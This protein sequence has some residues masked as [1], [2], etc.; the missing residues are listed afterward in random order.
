M[1]AAEVLDL[2]RDLIR[3]DTT[4]TGDADTLTG[5]R[6]AAEYVAERLSDAGYAPEYVEGGAAGRGNVVVRLP[7]ADPSRPALLV[8]GHLDVVPADASDW[9]V[10]PFSGEVEGGYLWGRGAVDMKHM[11]AMSLAV[12]RRFKRDGVVPA[13]D[14]VFA[15]LA[16]E[17][18]GGVHGARWLVDHRPDLF[19]GCTEAVSE[20]GGFSVTFDNGARAYLVETAEKGAMVLTLRARGAAGHASLLHER[21]A[22]DLLT[23]A[24]DRL[25]RHRFPLVLTGPVREFLEAVAEVSGVPFDPDDPETTVAR[26]G[27]LSRLV[28]ATLRD[29]ATVTMLNAGYKANVVPGTAAATVDCRILPGRQEAFLDE[30]ARVVGPDVER[31]WYSMPAVETTFEGSIVDSMTAAV[32]HED[33]DARVLPYML[34]AS[35]DAKSFGLLGIRHFGFAPLRLPADLD[36]ASLFHGVDERVPVEAL[37]FGTRVLDRFLRTA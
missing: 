33:P 17:E 25:N 34:P 9:A 35:T 27:N 26:L 2:A 15:F 7:G 28:G 30:L 14:I 23:G 3:I 8:H 21:T 36:Y 16:D 29:T 20:V 37:E 13:R 18:A 24:V 4:N 5:E 19:E 31:D 32:I 1:T 11:V 10:H 22:I 12:A 6:A